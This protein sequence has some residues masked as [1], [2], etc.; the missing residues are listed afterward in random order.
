MKWLLKYMVATKDLGLLFDSHEG[1]YID[2]PLIRFVDSN[3]VSVRDTRRSTTG[4]AFC[5]AFL[6]EQSNQLPLF[7]QTRL[8]ILLSWK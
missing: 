6:E 7:L 4:M 1:N 8:N 3:Y 2:L 5:F